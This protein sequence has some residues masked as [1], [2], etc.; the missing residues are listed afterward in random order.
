[1][2]CRGHRVTEWQLGSALFTA[3]VAAMQ[4]GFV[5]VERFPEVSVTIVSGV[6][7]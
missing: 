2:W 4:R 7:A 3:L 1:M 6:A 5:E